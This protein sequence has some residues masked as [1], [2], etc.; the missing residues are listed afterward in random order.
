MRPIAHTSAYR[1]E[2]KLLKADRDWWTILRMGL[3]DARDNGQGVSGT[4]QERTARYRDLL[5][6]RIRI[7]CHR[8][9]RNMPGA[10]GTPSRQRSRSASTPHGKTWWPL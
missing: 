3:V 6:A 9:H 8:F 10:Y 7:E 5:Y 1:P 4:E 2:S